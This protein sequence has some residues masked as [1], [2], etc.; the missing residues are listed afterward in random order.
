MK[1]L[2]EKRGAGG[3][4]PFVVDAFRPEDAEGI[5]RLF[6]AVYGEHY[7]IRLFYDPAALTEANRDGRYYSIVA[8][9]GRGEVI[10]VTHLYPSSPYPSLYEFGV[11]LVLKEYRNAG[12]NTRLTVYLF[13]EFIP[14]RPHIEEIFG[15]AVCNH[16]YT[17]RAIEP[18]RFIETGIEVALMPAEAYAREKS[19]PGR[20]A[21]VC[22]FRCF[23]PKPHRVYLPAAY[24]TFL[25]RIYGRLDD[26][27][28][29]AVSGDP[30]P[31]GRS[32]RAE[33]TVFDFAK[34]A[35]IA[36]RESGADL[37]TCL[38]RRETEAREKGVMV[39][40]AWLNLAEPW[41][42][43]AADVLREAGYFFGGPLPR[44]F[45]SDGFLMQ[46]LLCPP[47]FEDI[48]LHTDFAK[49]LLEFIRKDKSEVAS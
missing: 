49:E 30:L 9:T 3:G 14:R 35:R 19:A 44:W 24:E 20:V 21:T 46:K 16:P 2:D 38:D 8:R 33:M 27:R 18:F 48:V 5:A 11:G 12:V 29:L 23:Q 15:E 37:G 6:R 13:D 25:R 28:D 34:V 1:D 4:E 22:G 39:F 43:K 31:P 41:A 42:G 32:T 36:V 47:D 17:Q 7:P 45:D 10:G 26:R 40:Q